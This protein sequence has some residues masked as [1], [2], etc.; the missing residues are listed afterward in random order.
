M[1]NFESA[2]LTAPLARTEGWTLDR[3]GELVWVSATA[4]PA[5]IERDMSVDPAEQVGLADENAA[6]ATRVVANGLY[7]VRH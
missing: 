6:L 7:L 4:A 1:S 2:D 5:A 3:S